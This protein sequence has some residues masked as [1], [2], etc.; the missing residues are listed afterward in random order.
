VEFT[1]SGYQLKLD[2]DE[3]FRSFTMTF[4]KI[5]LTFLIILI[6]VSCAY[7]KKTPKYETPRQLT[8]EQAALVA[9][10]IQREKVL[11]DDIKLRTPLVETYIQDTRP[12]P[13]LY[14]VPVDDH[15]ILSRVDFG[16]SFFDKT[17]APREEDKKKG[18]FFRSSLGA[19]TGLTK[20]L[21]LEKF[22]Y[23]DTGF[24][25]MMFIDPN[26]FDQQHYVFSF[27]RREFLGILDRK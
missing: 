10:A 2:L 13:K 6:G 18:G 5:S 9:K 20:L 15:Y 23:S 22:T 4:R 11:I 24:M 26:G 17:Y 27:V 3:A 16:K 1:K 25:E 19:I 8:P 7:A 21:G 12:D 14:E